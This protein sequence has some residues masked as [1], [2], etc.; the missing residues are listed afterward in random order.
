VLN[1][2]E[3]QICLI[4][5]GSSGLGATFARDL[6]KRG[7]QL[8]LFARR[9]D[10]LQ[11]VAAGLQKEALIVAG[12][13]TSPED[14]ARL[15]QETLAKF[16]RLDV[17]INNAGRGDGA[18][19][20]RKTQPEDI[21]GV[22]QIN[23]VSLVQ[24][25]HAVLPSMMGQKHGLIIN[26]SSPMGQLGLPGSSLYNSSKAGVSAFSQTLRREVKRFGVHV[27]DFRPGFTRS[28]MVNP[29][30]EA[31]LPKFVPVKDPEGV[32]AQGLDAALKGRS[33]CQTGGFIVHVGEWFNWHTPA[34]TD[35]AFARFFRR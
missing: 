25:T 29:D 17:L 21:D 18:G 4:T 1:T 7:A 19:S 22:L 10:R 12:D 14:R 31:R 33:V 23:L 30:V 27:M 5:G 16:G 34:L 20:F 13:I 11:E 26:V 15:L 24:L 3:N 28:E 35:R 9:E 2:Y 32:I 8:V 6:D